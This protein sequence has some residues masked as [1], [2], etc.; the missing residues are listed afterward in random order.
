M[1]E[2]DR[3]G[4]LLM[5]L[6][7]YAL[8]GLLVVVYGLVE[9]APAL[10]S[11]ACAGLMALLPDAEVQRRAGER[12][13][14]GDRGSASTSPRTA[15][16]ITLVTLLLWLV[17]QWGMGAPVPGLG[18]AMWVAGLIVIFILPLQRF[19][20]LWYVKAG[21]TI[22]ALA[23]L[24]SRTYLAATNGLSP[25]AWAAL[26]GSRES[27]AAVITQTRGT[28]TTILLWALWLVVPLGYFSLL[29]Q[30]V[31]VNPLSIVS[32]LAGA[33]AMLRSLRVRDGHVD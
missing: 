12:P 22:Y 9:N 14:R 30:Q 28:T 13:L 24:A 23:V 18:T 8:N 16:V 1:S 3:L 5:D 15:Q 19:N 32:P 27:A 26:V 10:L 31:F 29:V 4:T 2:L 20:L 7:I 25:E 21:I 33:Q 11:L 17:A 6:P